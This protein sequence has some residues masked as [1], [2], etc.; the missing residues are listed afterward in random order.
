[1]VLLLREARKRG[2]ISTPPCYT[3]QTT[4][5]DS[6]LGSQD[7][8]SA[9][10]GQRDLKESLRAGGDEPA[11][12]LRSMWRKHLRGGACFPSSPPV[13][14]WNLREVSDSLCSRGVGDIMST[15]DREG[16]RD[17]W[18]VSVHGATGSAPWQPIPKGFYLARHSW[19]MVKYWWKYKS[20]ELSH[21]EPSADRLILFTSQIISFA[22]NAHANTLTQ[23]HSES[24]IFFSPHSLTQNPPVSVVWDPPVGWG[25]LMPPSL[26]LPL[27]CLTLRLSATWYSGRPGP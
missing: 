9:W 12:S 26:V 14:R 27:T 19:V 1:M 13:G 25:N 11:L 18:S 4:T 7:Q 2:R 8:N 10:G 6:P 17:F 20:N 16:W 21:G 15:W 24:F 3:P 5:S 22:F 23:S